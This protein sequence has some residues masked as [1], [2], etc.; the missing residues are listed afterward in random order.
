MEKGGFYTSKT[1]FSNN[2]DAV[3]NRQDTEEEIES[4]AI[5]SCLSVAEVKLW[6]NH[7]Q[8]IKESRKRGAEKASETRKKRKEQRVTANVH[9]PKGKKRSRSIST[10]ATHKNETN[11][12]QV[13]TKRQSNIEEQ[14]PAD[15][16]NDDLQEIIPF[17]DNTI[18]RS[19]RTIKRP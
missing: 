4:L 7:L 16:D 1:P 8:E 17:L 11:T 15:E 3:K 2:S 18:T 14:L 13:Q 6:L 5:K 10:K 12:K 9:E 19:G